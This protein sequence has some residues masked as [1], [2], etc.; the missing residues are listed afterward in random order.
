[1]ILHILTR[2][3]SS[4]ASCS[5]IIPEDAR[6]LCRMPS[7]RAAVASQK[8]ATLII[9]HRDHEAV[10]SY[11]NT[12]LCCK[13]KS[14]LLWLLLLVLPNQFRGHYSGRFRKTDTV[15]SRRRAVADGEMLCRT[16][17]LDRHAELTCSTLPHAYNTSHSQVG[18][19]QPAA[20]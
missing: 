17:G 20:W 4:G 15:C 5:E 14:K 18:R 9:P 2:C 10:N 8:S 1:M 16:S 12:Q 13:L 6:Q 3:W 7:P 11:L 19:Q